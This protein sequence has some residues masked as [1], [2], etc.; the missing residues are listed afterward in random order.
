MNRATSHR[1]HVHALLRGHTWGPRPR[2]MT[3]RGCGA[4]GVR[5]SAGGALVL[6]SLVLVLGTSGCVGRRITT[7]TYQWQTVRSIH[8]AGHIRWQGASAPRQLEVLASPV[9]QSGAVA[10]ICI[11]GLDLRGL[12]PR[13]GWTEVAYDLGSLSTLRRAVVTR[14]VDARQSGT[15]RR[16]RVVDYYVVR[17]RAPAGWD[18]EP[19]NRKVSKTTSSA[20]FVLTRVGGNAP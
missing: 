17:V 12:H 7:W 10:G 20:D 13:N 19:R 1:A 9:P 15:E 8:V 2:W 4:R 16:T 3:S 11:L 18:V 6:L 14:K 5:R